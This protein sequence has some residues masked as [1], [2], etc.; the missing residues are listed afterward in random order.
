MEWLPVVINSNFPRRG[1]FGPLTGIVRRQ[2]ASKGDRVDRFYLRRGAASRQEGNV[3]LPFL[4]F[5]FSP[6][7]SARLF[8]SRVRVVF[9]E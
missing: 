5:P 8:P 3:F 6:W 9:S 4:L 7:R 1:S 2:A